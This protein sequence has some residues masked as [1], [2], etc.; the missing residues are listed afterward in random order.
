MDL[1]ITVT[2]CYPTIDEGGDF[3][4]DELDLA[5]S[6]VHDDMEILYKAFTCCP[7]Q[8]LTIRRVGVDSDPLAGCSQIVGQVTVEVPWKLPVGVGS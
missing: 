7:E 8:Q 6:S 4:I 1:T 5:A 2:R 3:D